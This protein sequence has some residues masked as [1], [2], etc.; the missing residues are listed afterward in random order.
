VALVVERHP[1]EARRAPEVGV[2]APGKGL[3]GD[4]W[5]QSERANPEAEVTLM[6]ADVA[7]LV[8]NGQDLSLP[9][10]NL[11]VALDLSAENLPTGS[12]LQV[13]EVVL[14]ITAKPHTGCLKFE[15]RFGAD[16]RALTGLDELKAARLRGHSRPGG[17]RRG[18]AVW[19][20]GAGVGAGLT[21][22]T[23][24]SACVHSASF[25]GLPSWSAAMPRIIDRLD[26]AVG[27]T[28]AELDLHIDYTRQV[29]S[30]AALISPEG[31][32]NAGWFERFDGAYNFADSSA[33]TMALNRFFHVTL[34]TPD[35]YLVW[36]IADFGRAGNVACRWWR[37][38]LGALRPSR[39]RGFCG[40][41]G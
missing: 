30:P 14:E 1:G 36:N 22:N 35:H 37:R 10:D 8:C 7:K 40:R 25:P 5:A 18:R 32:Y 11:L 4:R 12:R 29:P 2:F 27:R 41:T 33:F 20:C 17:E 28:P 24:P 34:D 31:T 38:P 21:R 6:R 13:G 16:A 9:G 26:A 3:L 19:G 15:R 39:S 23:P